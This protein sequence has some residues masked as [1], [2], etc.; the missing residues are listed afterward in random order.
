MASRKLPFYPMNTNSFSEYILLTASA[1]F[2]SVNPIAVVPTFL[3]MTHNDSPELRSRIAAK[4]SLA[5]GMVLAFFALAGT[6][7]LKLFGLSLPAIQ[8]A[9]SIVLLGISL[10]MMHARRSAT[11]ETKDETHAV[12]ERESIA[13]MPLAIPMLADPGAISTTFIMLNRASD[14]WQKFV[15]YVCLL[16]VILMTFVI[17]RLSV[18]GARRLGPNA[19]KMMSRLMGLLLCAMAIQ[20]TINALKQMGVPLTI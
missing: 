3:S 16:A 18:H 19:Q 20:F 13:L 8:I 1:L 7:V 4:A 17:L 15:F 14:I 6:W 9:G 5:A 2:I 12:A 10:D 11:H